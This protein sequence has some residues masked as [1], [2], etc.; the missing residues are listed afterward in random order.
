MLFGVSKD[1]S[2]LKISEEKFSAAFHSS[3]ALMAMSTKQ[4]GKF[5]DVNEAFL[6]TMGFSRHEIIGKRISELNLFTQPEDRSNALR[7]LDERGKIRDLEVQ[8]NA[9]DGSV[10][11]GLFSADSTLGIIIF[12]QFSK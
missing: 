10:Q 1:L 11:Y 9:K 4:D 2:E 12:G 6:E 3:A 8:V 5:I 7:V